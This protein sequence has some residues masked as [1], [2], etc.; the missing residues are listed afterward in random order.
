[1]CNEIVYLL[2]CTI[3]FIDVGT[4]NGDV[5]PPLVHDEEDM[6]IYATH[7]KIAYSSKHGLCHR[8]DVIF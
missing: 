7:P 1:M 3:Y 8:L 2:L 4:F 5:S 6:D